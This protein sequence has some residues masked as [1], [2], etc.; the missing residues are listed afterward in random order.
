MNEIEVGSIVGVVGLAMIV[1]R[2]GYKIAQIELKTNTIWDFLMRR[3][4]SEA[5]SQG[6]AKMNSPLII[7]EEAKSWMHGLANDLRSFYAR[8]GRHLTDKELALE[9]ERRFGQE[10]LE[11][12]C[13]PHGLFAGAC[14][15]I[16]MEIAKEINQESSVK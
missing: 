14:L 15:L 16:A 9:I 6:I 2:S 4:I 1:F 10:I 5:V 7:S 12:V 8:Q 3:S 11:R 13:I